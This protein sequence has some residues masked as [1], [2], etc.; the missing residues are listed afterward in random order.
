VHVP[1]AHPAGFQALGT[2]LA[3][4]AA[5][6]K[7]DLPPW[8][9]LTDQSPEHV[10]SWTEWLRQVW[11]NTT[12]ADAIGHASP[13]LA[14]QVSGLCAAE[15]PSARDTY[16][17]MLAVARYLQRLAGRPT[18]FGLLAGVAPAVFGAQARL[19]WG[20]EHQ[21][22]ARA[23]ADWLAEVITHL[24][25][26]PALLAR[27]PVVANS[28]IAVRGDRLVVPYRPRPHHQGTAAVEVSLRHTAVVAAALGVARTPIRMEDLAAKLR[29][30]FPAA[31]P[32]QVTG[33]LTE[34]VAQGALITS[35]HAP[36]TEPDALGHLV[37]ELQAADAA[38]VAEVAGLV[39]DLRGIHALLEDH[40]RLPTDA[41]RVM[42]EELAVRMRRMAR[43]DRHPLAVD[44]RLDA[45]LVLPEQV[46]REAERAVLALTRLSARPYGTAAWRSYHQRFY[47]RYGIGSLVPVLDVVADSGIGWPDGYPGTVTPEPPS[48]ASSRDEMLLS[49]AQSAALDDRDE[50]V[51]DEEL[52]TALDIGPARPRTP[53]HLE[54]GVR[55]HA[56]SIEALERG[57][58]LLEVVSVSRAAGILTG[59]FLSV[60]E[61]RD[62][63]A[64]TAVL[65]DLPAAD[66]QTVAAQLSFPPLD[67]ATAHV[68]RA[69]QALP[70]VISLAE[71]RSPS[72]HT[73]TVEDLAVG[74]DGRRLY[75]AAPA[76]G[77]RVEAVGMH[78][79]SLRTHT[80]PLAR[81]LSELSRA[82]N[83]QVTVFDWGAARKLPFLPR[84]RYG[85]TILAPAR[86]RLEAADLPSRAEP[87]TAWDDALTSWRIRRRLPR[88]VHLVEGDRRLPLD[89]G[90][91]AHRVLLR[92]HL[93]THPH[94]VLIEALAPEASGWCGGRPHEVVIPVRAIEP[95]PWPRLP[96][97]TRARVIGRDHGHAP[98]V[99]KVLLACLYGDIHRQDVIL[100]EHLPGLLERLGDPEWWYVRYRDPDQH[101]RLRIALPDPAAFG[102]VA[103]EVSTW[104][105]ELRRAGLLRALVYPTSYPEPGRWGSG[106]A[107]RAA[108]KV[109][110]TDSHA[111]L[112]QLR[113]PHRPHR[114][115]LVAAH[116]VAIATAF[117]GSTEAGM[118]WLIEHIPAAAPAKITRP[119]F[120][121]AVRISD[122]SAGWAALRAAPGGSAIAD[123]W[124]AR[125]QALATYRACFPGPDTRGVDVDD[126]LGSLMHVNY[127]R[128][129]GIDFP[130]EA[131]CLYLARA[132]ALAWR[133]RATGSRP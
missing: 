3:R 23:G 105:A 62:Q 127:V 132:A 41:A 4:A 120:A 68:A 15:A 73:L 20:T 24:E 6:P 42:R 19:R 31:A 106:P 30:E 100:A 29:A 53:S 47:E 16:R 57:D 28:T 56:A 109:F 70:F 59:R 1:N 78:A 63:A 48:R 86:W 17:A 80:P 38:A 77:C 69:V 90:V 50:V 12:V 46:A 8:P 123:A 103:A 129:C 14:A 111:L 61:P 93:A 35:L 131:E 74:C 32:D 60:L 113:L 114:Q 117:T 7:L 2:A 81:F 26:C 118:R 27:L 67:P 18:P 98:A 126:V 43:T 76:L 91:T 116:T 119:L 108:E 94:A 40:N 79:L 34:L 72:G 121:E 54:L 33:L 110:G 83:A 99:S 49:L 71:H 89:L 125:D 95:P 55:V 10:A 5:H 112:V 37:R 107:L 84:L 85:R 122:A 66:P 52:V 65:G 101:L 124:T 102:D 36:S 128:A 64:Q 11:K 45:T 22:V 92:A 25:G 88:L 44:L 21:G 75:L 39:E 115:A 97:P 96:A 87:W 104:S 9:D 58:F 51:V 130:D 82:N 133:A 13:V